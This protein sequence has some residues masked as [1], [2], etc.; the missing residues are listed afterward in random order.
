LIDLFIYLL[1]ITDMTI[2]S[3]SQCNYWL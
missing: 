1:H 3:E 2:R